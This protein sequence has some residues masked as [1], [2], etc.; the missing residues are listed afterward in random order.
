[1]IRVQGRAVVY[2][3][4]WFDEAPP[5]G[6]GAA[7]V[8]V[9]V[10]RYRAALVPN[11]RPC[12]RAGAPDRPLHSL[13]TDLEPAPETIV[14]RFDET[15]RRHIR[16]AEREDGLRFEVL[17]DAAAG[18]DEFAQFYDMFAR[19]KG[20]WLADRH[21]LTRTAEAGQLTL[22]CASRGGERLVWHAHLRAGCTVQLAHSVSLYRGTGDDYRSL[23]ARANRWLHWQDMLAFR[24]AGL[25][26]YDWGGMFDPESTAEEVGINRFKRSFGGRPVLAYQCAVPVT[27]RGRVW[28]ILSGALR[29]QP[30]KRPR[31]AAASAA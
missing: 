19:Q 24:A 21:W 28:L 11:A 6:A 9:L 12:P 5:Q 20:L 4:V 26:R 29:R 2:G 17:A 16:R 18:L 25:R 27:L 7:G 1:M 15:C 30:K 13:L 22:S 8:D 31:P 10:Y 23:I 14:A 3:E